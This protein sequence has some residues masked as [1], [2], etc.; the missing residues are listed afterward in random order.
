MRDLKLFEIAIYPS[1]LMVWG[2]LAFVGATVFSSVIYSERNAGI[3]IWFGSII[4][5]GSLIYLLLVASEPYVRFV[6]V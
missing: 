3:R 6:W 4:S 2:A 5:W 1:L